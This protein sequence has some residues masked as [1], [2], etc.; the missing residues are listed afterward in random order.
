[1]AK[2]KD[3][4]Y[5]MVLYK[6]DWN[7]MG[8]FPQTSGRRPSFQPGAGI[9]MRVLHDDPLA[10]QP[11][12]NHIYEVDKL[13]R[14]LPNMNIGLS[15]YR[16]KPA[17]M[18]STE[19]IEKTFTRWRSIHGYDAKPVLEH[20]EKHKQ[21]FNPTLP[22]LSPFRPE[23]RITKKS[24]GVFEIAIWDEN[25]DA[26]SSIRLL[27]QCVAL[28]EHEGFEVFKLE[29][30]IAE[31]HRDTLPQGGIRRAWFQTTTNVTLQHRRE[32]ES[33]ASVFVVDEVRP[34]L[35]S[36]KVKP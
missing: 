7:L 22:I 19:K 5:F 21:I 9:V 10:I 27:Q 26:T 1:M 32:P 33:L 4:K 15:D 23:M 25:N 35:M 8:V 28:A 18:E 12:E 31:E 36:D 24:T 34:Y 3:A 11:D 2:S 17:P 16:Q 14:D 6:D 20:Q 30:W 13:L 29:N